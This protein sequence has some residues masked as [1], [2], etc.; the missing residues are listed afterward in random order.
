MVPPDNRILFIKLQKGTE[1]H[2]MLSERSQAYILY[3]SGYMTSWKR[4]NYRERKKK[5]SVREGF[6]G[7]DE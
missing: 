3:D 6:T 7:K 1:A 4:Q 5:K 2:Q